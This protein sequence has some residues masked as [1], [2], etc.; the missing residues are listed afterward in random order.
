MIRSRRFALAAA[1]VLIG[2]SACGDAARTATPATTSGKAPVVIHLGSSGAAGGAENAAADRMMMP[3]QE[4]DYVYDGAFPELAGTG[5]A[6]M[7][8]AGVQLDPAVVARLAHV[9]GVDGDVRQLP[10]DQ[11]GG[12]MVG[13]ADYSTATLTISPDGMLS[14]WYNPDPSTFDYRGGCAVA[15]PGVAVDPAVDVTGETSSGSAGG[16]TAA[17]PP[18]APTP[19]DTDTAPIDTAPIDTVLPPDEVCTPQPPA[20][21]PDEAAA[22]A[23]A[24][25]LL[26]DIGLDPTTYEFE[27]Y[28]DEWGANVTGYLLVGGHRSP[29]MF[30]VGFGEDGGITWA[31]GSLA[32]PQPAAEYPLVG[33]AAGLERLNE[34]SGMWMAYGNMAYDTLG[35][36]VAR[37]AT[38]EEAANEVAASDAAGAPAPTDT[39]LVDP[40]CDALTPE[41]LEP[42]V[43]PVP[44]DQPVCDP[45]TDCVIEPIVPL[46]PITVHL[47]D[48]TLDLTMV[49]AEDGTVWLLPA[50]SFTSTDG[51]IYSVIAVDDSFIDLPDPM[52]VPEPMPVE[53]LPVGSLPV[54]TRPIDVGEPVPGETVLIDADEAARLL[55]GLSFDEA[56]KVAE[57]QGWSVRV[58][59]LDGESQPV[60]MDLRT[61]RVN[62]SVVDGVITAIDSIG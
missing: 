60:T 56:G 22:L 6:W 38:S 18:D 45:A 41:C 21:V 57:E 16:G 20:N 44:I 25:A 54:E 59:T 19:P 40:T 58:T 2:L 53:S 11:G 1:A 15:E 29:L 31:S 36:A 28:A 51:G 37:S 61:D 33:V 48:V 3:M 30:S 9:L 23:A 55:V 49:W 27:T 43:E 12:W 13:A 52:P 7:L 42:A 8:P 50:Y 14:W 26:T 24:Q 46:D 4:I 39:V 35:G 5:S 32:T 47:N 17:A 10:A 34:E 62:V